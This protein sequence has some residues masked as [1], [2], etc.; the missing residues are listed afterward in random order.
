MGQPLRR[1]HRFSLASGGANAV[2]NA[3]NP[4][5]RRAISMGSGDASGLV[6]QIGS[7]SRGCCLL[8]ALLV[9]N[10]GQMTD[11]IRDTRGATPTWEDFSERFDRCFRRVSYYV[12]RRVTDC[13][14]IERIV[15][16]V[17]TGSADL[18]IAQRSELE[19][20]K[21]LKA[22]ADRLLALE[23]AISS[24]ASPSSPPCEPGVLA[25]AF[26]TVTRDKA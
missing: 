25:A 8:R 24:G 6:L 19:E 17:L 14:S 13:E 11:T 10:A 4:Q 3:S 5:F 16:E 20:I 9:E 23:T 12:G 26:A 21:C 22:S 2:Q 1:C 7:C 15:T 18:L